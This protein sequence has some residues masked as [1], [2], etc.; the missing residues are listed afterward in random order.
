MKRVF[1]LLTGG[2]FLV[3]ILVIAALAVNSIHQLAR[4]QEQ[5][6]SILEP[7]SA[8]LVTVSE[9]Q[10]AAY[11]RGDRL[12]RMAMEEDPFARDQLFLEFNRAGFLVGSGRQK[13]LK[14]GLG[15]KERKLFD[16]QSALIDRIVP[17]QEKVTDYL[18]DGRL[19]IARS[20]LI[21]EGIPMQESFIEM[22]EEL[23]QEMQMAHS[24][25]LEKAEEDY[26]RGR[27]ITLSLSISAVMLG[28]GLATFTLRRLANNAREIERQIT[29]L[30]TS[31]AAL[32]V[33]VTHDAMTGLANRKLFY[34]RLKQAMLHAKRYNRKVGVLFVDLDNFKTVND[35][36]GHHI[37][38]ALLSEVSKR[39][40]ESVRESDTVARAGGDE[41]LIMLGNLNSKEDCETAID[42]IEG[43]LERKASLC[44]VELMI[45]ASI[46]QAIYP[47][48][49]VTEDALIRVADASM[50]RIKTGQPRSH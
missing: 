19:D 13:L 3:L 17:M 43:G 34:D 26:Q 30:K 47:E 9:L 35:L 15:V 6:A 31:R 5:V 48:D 36:Y 44:G 14:L 21:A 27:L 22:L 18:G 38:D 4:S 33:E 39:L 8:R 42:K 49:G 28:L 50:Y 41:F 1:L 46:G 40:Q 25:A 16:E 20:I 23:H 10:V 32:E 12:L 7:Y 11:T 29:E 24:L 2:A 37:G 45:S